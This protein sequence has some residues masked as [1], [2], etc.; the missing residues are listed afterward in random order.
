VIPAPPPK[1]DIQVVLDPEPGPETGCAPAQRAPTDAEA[2]ALIN[3]DFAKLDQA[4]RLQTLY[5][6]LGH[7]AEGHSACD[8]NFYRYGVGQVMNMTSWADQIVATRFI[9]PS[10][11]I[12]RFDVRE[13][14]WTA[15]SL[16][17][18]LFISD[19]PDYGLLPGV[20]A[21][22]VAVRADWLVQHL[23][24]APAY[25]YIVGNQLHERL[26]EAQAGV[27]NSVRGRFGGVY[28]S[29]VAL[30]PRLL[31]RRESKY[32]SCWIAHD[33]LYR[34]QAFAAMESGV[35]PPDDLRFA[36][37]SYIA[38]EYICSLP[39]GLQSYALT[40]FI[41]QRRWDVPTCVAQNQSREDKLVLN[42]QCFN[43]H[44]DGLIAFQDRVRGGKPNPSEAIKE[45][46]PEQTELD[47]LFAKD[48]ARYDAALAKISH[49]DPSYSTPLNEMIGLYAERA[50]ANLNEVKGG[51]FAAFLPRGAS[52]GPAWEKVVNPLLDLA[53]DVGILLPAGLL[54]Q[55]A[56]E[57]LFPEF[58]KK[59]RAAGIDEEATCFSL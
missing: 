22:A 33:F 47:A 52:G 20:S 57:M 17:Y 19:R 39:N 53:V 15:D 12:A 28:T 5:V 1:D 46:F 50:K 41:S 3:S 32:G 38:R 11:T 24:R 49:Y 44:A 2:A 23:T 31:E 30:N 14:K 59:Y 29:I 54:Y 36:L 48:Q 16:Q 51:T 42:G 4:S 37:Q 45:R 34:T 40:G 8:L 56:A 9:D 55:E 6:T 26:I 58:E 10:S 13:L 25:T 7:L 27:D 35:L 43:C 18:L 21:G